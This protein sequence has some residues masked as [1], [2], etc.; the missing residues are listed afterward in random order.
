MIITF[1]TTLSGFDTLYQENTSITAGGSSQLDE[2]IPD[3]STDLD[4]TI[5][6]PNASASDSVVAMGI[7]SDQDV[8]VKI[9]L[10]NDTSLQSIALTAN[11]PYV[12][13]DGQTDPTWRNGGDIAK[14]L[15]T[16]ASGSAAN[17]KMG[18][19]YDPTP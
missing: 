2:S 1:S 4:V 11:E 13:A 5:A 10:A 3:E 7:L 12:W 17:L 8:T 16:N 19:L 14:V 18:I 9:A 6:A 15:V